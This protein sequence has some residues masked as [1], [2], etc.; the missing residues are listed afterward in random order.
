MVNIRGK[1]CA[2]KGEDGTACTKQPTFNEPGKSN[3]IFCAKHASPNMENVNCRRCTWKGEDDAKCAKVPSFNEPGKS[4]GIFCA[5]H[6]SSTM[7]DVRSLKCTW[8][9][10]DGASCTKQPNFNKPGESLAIFC[11]THASAGMTN[12]KSAKCTWKG[13]DGETCT[14]IP[15]YNEPGQLLAI[16][17]AKHASSTMVDVKHPKCTWKGDDGTICTKIPHFNEPGKI[18]VLF[19]SKH[20]KIGMINVRHL[21][22]KTL[23]CTTKASN[24][25]YKGYCYRCFIYEYPNN[26]IVRNHKTK[27]RSVAD[28]I[29]ARYP[30]LTITFDRTVADGCSRRRPDIL[31]DLGEYVIITEVDESQHD[32]YDCTCENKRLM[33]LF[34]DVGSRPLVM[35]RFNP[36]KYINQKQKSVASCWGYTKEKGLCVVK[37]NKTAEWD[38]RLAT[39]KTT[40]DLV[41]SQGTDSEVR[42]IHLFYDGF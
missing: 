33:Q 18:Q 8:K 2:W 29:R 40:L 22:C 28:Y 4:Q 26:T 34:T 15:S 3:G 11:A 21:T 10:E 13:E 32:A 9:G 39:L 37:P 25:A 17:C 7:I 31:M 23:H 42:V 12:I 24:K 16:F 19:C 30:D 27:E 14:K 38:Q 36:D 41:M 6:A 35:V 20:A 1:K 5:K